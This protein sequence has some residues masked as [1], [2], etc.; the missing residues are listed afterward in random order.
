VYPETKQG[1]SLN[2]D[3]ET[4]L[5]DGN[6]RSRR[7]VMLLAGNEIDARKK[8]DAAR[9]GVGGGNVSSNGD[10]ADD[11]GCFASC[12]RGHL[13]HA[14]CF[15][16]ALLAGRCCP[17]P[18][19]TE[20]LWVPKVR[21]L[22]RDDETCCG[23]NASTEDRTAETELVDFSAVARAAEEAEDTLNEQNS[24][25]G[26][27]ELKMCPACCS[28]PIFNQDCADMMSHHG[29]CSVAA[30]GGGQCRFRATASDIATRMIEVSSTKTVVDVLPKCPTHKVIVMF[31]GCMACGRLFTD[32]SWNKLPKWD[33]DAKA[34][35][36]L[37]SKKR[38]A[39][40]VLAREVQN[41]AALLQFE[42]DA[43]QNTWGK[44][45]D[46]V[47]AARGILADLPPLPPHVDDFV[48]PGCGPA[49]NES[50]SNDGESF[51]RRS[52]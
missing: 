43:L 3:N 30:V 14:R 26:L 35:M 13:L 31:N 23:G 41:E 51:T 50:H 6:L 18:T 24:I 45:V 49:C 16:D 34:L 52:P 28:G 4:V 10:K 38:Q 39:A 36:E 12:A 33:P 27:G 2:F 29:Q 21:Q 15:Q 42:R 5:I 46:K 25:S 44:G 48:D 1:V 9:R 32:H 7:E 8:W 37:D 47:A 40:S 11:V 17:A 22:Q 19:C 20:P